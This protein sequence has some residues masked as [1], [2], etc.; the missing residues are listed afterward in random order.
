VD[1]FRNG[2]TAAGLQA[3]L[4]D[5]IPAGDAGQGFLRPTFIGKLWQASQVRRPLIDALGTPKPLT[6]LKAWGWRWGVKPTVPR[7]SGSKTDVHSEALTTVMDSEDA[8]DFAGGWDVARKFIDLGDAGFIQEVF[9]MATDDYK[10]QT[11]DYTR[12]ILLRDATA[13]GAQASIVGALNALGAASR[14]IGSNLSAIQFGSALW[15]EFAN[16][17]ES[18]VPWWLKAQGEVNLGTAEGQA[19]GLR[20]STSTDLDARGYLALDSRGASYHEVNPPIRVQA[21]DI[22]RGGV[23]LGVFGYACTFVHDPR[24]ILKGTVTAPAGGALTEGADAV[25]AAAEVEKARQA[26]IAKRSTAVLSDPRKRSER[27]QGE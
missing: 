16:L 2:G 23:D 14:A 6:G 8:V 13:I 25:K 10:K 24:T 1:H 26:V 3:A 12:E 19:G 21:V 7:Y 9:A 27:S 18:Q 17:P 5:T 11:E 20:F 22:A 15:E 4:A